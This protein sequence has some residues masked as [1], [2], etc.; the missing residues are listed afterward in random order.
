MIC[1][2]CGNRLKVDETRTIHGKTY[3]RSWCTKC[4]KILYSEETIIS[5]EYGIEALSEWHRCY[6]Q[7]RKKNGN[8]T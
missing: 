3:R 7:A 1:P 8:K 5:S 6:T 2:V 4:N